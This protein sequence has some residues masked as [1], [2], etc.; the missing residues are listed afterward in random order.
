V[1]PVQPFIKAHGV[2]LHSSSKHGNQWY[3]NG[4]LLD[5]ETKHVLVVRTV[6]NYTVSVTA[7]CGV[8]A[9]SETFLVSTNPIA[10]TGTLYPNPAIHQVALELPQGVTS[11]RARVVDANGQEVL[12]KQ[13]KDKNSIVFDISTLQKGIYFIE[14]QTNRGTARHKF[15]IQ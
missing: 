9:V 4:E 5:G 6:G 10:G 2:T 11:H 1:N 8:T 15:L 14:A 7:S 3:L 12:S 13:E